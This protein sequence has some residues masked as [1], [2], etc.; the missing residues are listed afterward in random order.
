MVLKIQ[1]KKL[2]SRALFLIY[3][4][5]LIIKHNF[6]FQIFLAKF[7]WEGNLI[8]LWSHLIFVLPLM[9]FSALGIAIE[10]LLENGFLARAFS[11]NL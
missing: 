8:V 7:S 4:P 5:L 3:I 9:L 1:P 2:S 11:Q 10:V 6:G